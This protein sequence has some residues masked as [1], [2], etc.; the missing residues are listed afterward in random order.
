MTQTATNSEAMDSAIYNPVYDDT[1]LSIYNTITNNM[2]QTT[3]NEVLK[4]YTN[5]FYNF[6]T[7]NQ[8]EGILENPIYCDTQDM[9]SDLTDVIS[10]LTN[11]YPSTDPDYSDI[12]DPSN[13]NSLISQITGGNS[14]TYTVSQ[15]DVLSIPSGATFSPNSSGGY[16]V[17][18]YTNNNA[19]Q[20]SVSNANTHINRIVS[21]L[22]AMMAIA[23]S[24]MGL[25]TSLQNLNNPCINLG[26][27]FG[28]IN[29]IAKK[30]MTYVN[31]IIKKIKAYIDAGL[32]AIKAAIDDIKNFLSDIMSQ[33]TDLMNAVKAEITAFIKSLID[34]IKL[35]LSGFLKS[36]K[37]DPCAKAILK[38]VGTPAALFSV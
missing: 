15:D 1:D 31:G 2:S 20:P 8:Y 26:N 6:S 21:N 19:I 22:P 17:T 28:T 29:G 36:L 32:D 34:S 3:Y 16:D 25:L 23:Q 35:G 30:C 14:N 37:L 33:I 4:Q 12:A 13:P 24:A 38:S 10:G 18:S 11:A 27:F 9:N 7:V 5:M